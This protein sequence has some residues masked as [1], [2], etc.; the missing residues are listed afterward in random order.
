MANSW[1]FWP[2]SKPRDAPTHEP[3]PMPAT[4]SATSLPSRDP[5]VPRTHR[6]VLTC[7]NIGPHVAEP[8]IALEAKTSAVEHGGAQGVSP[9]EAHLPRDTPTH[10]LKTMPATRNAASC[11][12]KR[13]PKN[14]LIRVSIGSDAAEAGGACRNARPKLIDDVRIPQRHAPGYPPCK[15]KT[16]SE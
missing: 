10:Q 14:H 8:K 12:S 13:G 5:N 7:S 16:L 9:T 15:T 3:M 2:Q 1:P 11:L 6:P 4:L